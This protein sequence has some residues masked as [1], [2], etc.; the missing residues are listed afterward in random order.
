L[1]PSTPKPA[2][3]PSQLPPDY[4][5]SLI[6]KTGL[7]LAV[8]VRRFPDRSQLEQLCRAIVSDITPL[9]CSAVRAGD[10][11]NYAAPGHLS[12]LLHYVCVTNCD[13]GDIRFAIEEAIPNSKEWHAMLERLDE[14][15]GSAATDASPDGQQSVANLSISPFDELAG[16]LMSEAKRENNG[17]LLDGEFSRIGAEID[18][19]GF[20]LIDE[21]GGLEGKSRDG[22][23]RWN[24]ANSGKAIHTYAEALQHRPLLRYKKAN[25]M[26]EDYDGLQIT[27]DLKR[28]A[29]RRLYRAQQ[30]WE[31]YRSKVDTT[32]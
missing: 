5:S 14:C 8:A 26:A 19:A 32:T 10:L 21:S 20:K 25:P 18:A 1:V 27:L 4:P 29:R 2:A 30:R 31:A 22:L 3:V 12:K 6:I 28:A 16:R 17:R 23:A 15:E 9:F 24:K 7:I 11:R 13:N